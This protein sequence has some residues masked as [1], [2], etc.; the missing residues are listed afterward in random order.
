MPFTDRCM[1]RQSLLAEDFSADYPMGDIRPV[2]MAIQLRGVG[3]EH[4]DVMQERCLFNEILV[5]RLPV[6]NPFGDPE[7]KPC[8]QVAVGKQNAPCFVVS[9]VILIY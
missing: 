3:K 8:N 4:T 1:T 5:N 6:S 7:G 2:T 9:C